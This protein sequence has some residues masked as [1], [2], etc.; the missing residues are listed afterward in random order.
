MLYHEKPEREGPHKC[1]LFNAN[2]IERVLVSNSFEL[3]LNIVTVMATA[4]ATTVRRAALRR[5]PL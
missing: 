5:R 3:H 4:T 1:E 2:N